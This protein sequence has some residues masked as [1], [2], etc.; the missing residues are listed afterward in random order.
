MANHFK[1]RYKVCYQ[2]KNIIWPYKNSRLRKFYNL[3]SSQII[4]RG[5]SK[6]FLVA[7]NMKWTVVRRFVVPFTKTKKNYMFNY[8]NTLRLKQQLKSFYGKLRERQLRKIFKD[9]WNKEKRFKLQAFGAALEKRLDM[10]VFRMRILPTIFSVHQ[11]ISH[12][13]VYVNNQLVTL[14]NYRIDVGDIV[15]VSEKH[16]SIFYDSIYYKLENRLHAKSLLKRR[17]IKVLKNLQWSTV[18]TKGNLKYHLYL[19][20]EYRYVRLRYNNLL[21]FLDDKRDEYTKSNDLEKSLF[22]K[23]LKFLIIKQMKNEFIVVNKLLVD[24]R[25]WNF[26]E[27]YSVNLYTLLLKIFHLHNILN[28]STL[29]LRQYILIID[30]QYNLMKIENSSDTDE[31]KLVKVLKLIKKRNYNLELVKLNYKLKKKKLKYKMKDYYEKHLVITTRY[32]RDAK[33]DNFLSNKLIKSFKYQKQRAELFP[34]WCRK[35]HWYT[36]KYLEI[37]YKTLRAGFIY[38]PEPK[39]IH[40]AFNCSLKNIVTFYKE[41]GL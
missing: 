9:T 30:S 20:K 41:R 38:N 10:V 34:H 4:E 14:P 2:S 5:Q 25:E 1:P 23:K 24:F 6:Q 8:G 39:E 29:I 40:Y 13:G 32:L 21:K 37:D 33:Y 22:L 27:G 15:G 35:H 17:K 18:K 36:P 11:L 3:R 19:F 26:K 12:H 28:K 31:E 7:K 16:W